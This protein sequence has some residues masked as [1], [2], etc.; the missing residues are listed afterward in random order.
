MD[1]VNILDISADPSLPPANLSIGILPLPHVSPCQRASHEP[2]VA[3]FFCC[4]RFRELSFEPHLKHDG[5]ICDTS[6]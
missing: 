5:S 1:G 3:T 4:F 2:C 6:A